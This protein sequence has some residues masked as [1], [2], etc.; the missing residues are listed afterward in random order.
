MV[1]KNMLTK[2]IKK[3]L[4]VF[5][6][7]LRILSS[8]QKFHIIISAPKQKKSFQIIFKFFFDFIVLQIYQIISGEIINLST[9]QKIN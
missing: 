1:V 3:Y 5:M 8:V 4:T 6:I 7:F 2:K 9:K